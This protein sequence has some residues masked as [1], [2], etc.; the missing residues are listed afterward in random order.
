MRD[1]TKDRCFAVKSNATGMYHCSCCGKLL[2]ES[3]KDRYQHFNNCPVATAADEPPLLPG[4]KIT[5]INEADTLGFRLEAN[6]GKLILSICKPCLSVNHSSEDCGG[7]QWIPVMEAEIPNNSKT[8]SILY[9]ETEMDMHTLAAMIDSREIVQIMK[10]NREEIRKVFPN[11]LGVDSFQMFLH[12]HSTKGFS[13]GR[14]RKDLEERLLSTIPSEV[15]WKKLCQNSDKQDN[16]LPILATMHNEEGDN[17]LHLVVQGL[18]GERIV[19]LFTDQYSV[20]SDTEIN[21]K[22]VL[23]RNYRLIGDSINAIYQFDKC[24][25][26]FHISQYTEQSDNILIPLIAPEFHA[27][28]ELVTNGI[29]H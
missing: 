23:F 1:R 3:S 20:C 27:G 24:Y 13:Q 28:M 29:L 21:I 26:S 7:I 15:E 14:L 6:S 16:R 5:Y 8:T 2:G 19:F 12:I 11:V 9:N 10:T 17:I 25:P 22:E 18:T 4:E